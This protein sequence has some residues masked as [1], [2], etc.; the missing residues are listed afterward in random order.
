MP[1]T[2]SLD[3]KHT[4]KSRK[5]DREGGVNPYSYPDHK[6]YFSRLP[7]FVVSVV[8]IVIV[9]CLALSVFCYVTKSN[10]ITGV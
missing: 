1:K 3:Q 8:M 4:K 10:K 2:V 5:A 9:N 6:I 7:L